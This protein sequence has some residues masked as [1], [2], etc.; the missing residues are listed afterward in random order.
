MLRIVRL[1]CIECNLEACYHTRQIALVIQ[2]KQPL[3][4]QLP[5]SHLT[6]QGL[7]QPKTDGRLRT[8]L[9]IATSHTCV[10]LP[11]N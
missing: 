4:D 3:V 7:L 2:L 6:G 1:H 9:I 11:D 10:C 8:G 5:S